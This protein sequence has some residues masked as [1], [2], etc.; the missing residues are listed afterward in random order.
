M[1]DCAESFEDCNAT[2]IEQK[3]TALEKVLASSPKDRHH[4]HISLI[5]RSLK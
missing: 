2:A 4:N 3:I 1:G 5:T